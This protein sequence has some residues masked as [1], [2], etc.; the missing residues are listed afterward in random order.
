MTQRLSPV[1]ERLCITF[2]TLSVVEILQ[3]HGVLIDMLRGRGIVTTRDNPVGGYA[4]W[5][6]RCAF[7]LTA[8]KNS[9]KGFDAVDQTGA[10]YQIKGG[11]PGDAAPK[12]G[13]VKGVK[14][15]NFDYLV[16][17][18]FNDNFTIKRAVKVPH[19]TVLRLASKNGRDP[20]K[21]LNLYLNEG[22]VRGNRLNNIKGI[23]WPCQECASE[24]P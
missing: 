24:P 7:E 4:E 15:Q 23:L 2:E 11:R 5:L 18:T 21:G 16:A 19:E 6:A 13:T 9:T 22:F 3:A 14:P 10:K 8:Q 1:V 12:L 20:T 17:M